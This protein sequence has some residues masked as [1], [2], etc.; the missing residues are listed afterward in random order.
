MVVDSRTK[1]SR[2]LSSMFDMIEKEYCTT[3]LLHDMDIS[4][5]IVYDQQI[6]EGKL[7]EEYKE[8]KKSS[9]EDDDPS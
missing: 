8:K 5:L 1:I 7:N 2:F 4:C 6:E 3:M 9:I